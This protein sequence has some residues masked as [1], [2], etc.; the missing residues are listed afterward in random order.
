MAPST[1][2]LEAVEMRPVTF[3]AGTH[4]LVL[5]KVAERRW[6]VVVDGVKQDSFFDTQADAWEAGVRRAYALDAPPA[7]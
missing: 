2:D 7:R 1:A 4:T 5:A 3:S 6:T